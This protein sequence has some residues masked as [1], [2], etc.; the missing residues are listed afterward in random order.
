MKERELNIQ[1]DFNVSARHSN[2]IKVTC[3]VSDQQAQPIF[4]LKDE[5]LRDKLQSHIDEVIYKNRYWKLSGQNALRHSKQEVAPHFMMPYEIIT[6]RIINANIFVILT[7]GILLFFFRPSELAIAS[8][9]GYLFSLC[10]ALF[11]YSFLL[12]DKDSVERESS[13]P[14]YI[15]LFSLLILLGSVGLRYYSFFT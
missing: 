15:L 8:T 12:K 9:L 5:K 13:I 14:S 4:G 6:P 10:L 3:E 7:S 1:I 11:A 2:F